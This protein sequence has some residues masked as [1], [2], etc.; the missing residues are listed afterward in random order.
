MPSTP[1]LAVTGATGQL[2]GL[3]VRELLARG[4]EPAQVRA[5]VRSPEKAGDLRALGVDVR[6]GDYDQPEQLAAALV[7]VDALVLV[8]ANVAGLR[9]PQHTRVVE[10]AVT[11]GVPRIVYTSILHADTSPML[12]A[13]EHRQTELLI[14]RTGLRHAFLRNGWYVENYTGQLPV[15][16]EHGVLSATQGHPLDVAPRAEFAAAAA[17]AVLDD[18]DGPL[19]LA[20]VP[21]TLSAYAAELGSVS[22]TDVP[23]VEVTE[24]DLKAALVGAGLPETFAAVLADADTGIA[25]GHLSDRSGTLARLIGRPVTPWQDAVA[26]AV[27]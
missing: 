8:S 19:E 13:E 18:L 6:G 14:E 5:V 9:L 1:V 22:G 12:L 23:V 17:V 27:G 10:A 2:G 11:A 21:M 20:G 16:L 15:Q 24:A 26:R 7:G 3:I 25:H 4:V